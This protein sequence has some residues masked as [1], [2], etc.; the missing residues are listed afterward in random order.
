MSEEPPPSSPILSYAEQ[1][2]DMKTYLEQT[3][4]FP[5]SPPPKLRAK[6][7][8]RYNVVRRGRLRGDVTHERVRLWVEL[9]LRMG[10]YVRKRIS[11]F[12]SVMSGGRGDFDGILNIG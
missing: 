10:D 9:P 2:R 8:K 1:Y 3:W 11:I 5:N 4:P 12:R 7:R 6:E